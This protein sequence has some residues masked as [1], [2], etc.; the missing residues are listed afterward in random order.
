MPLRKI[1]GGWADDLE[2]DGGVPMVDDEEASSRNAPSNKPSNFVL[3]LV[4]ELQRN[5]KGL[6]GAEL[7]RAIEVFLERL[8]EFH[9]KAAPEGPLRAEIER[10]LRGMVESD[11]FVGELVRELRAAPEG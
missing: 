5:A 11:P 1:D 2:E 9:A 10:T 3:L 6:Q 7:E 4:A 8:I